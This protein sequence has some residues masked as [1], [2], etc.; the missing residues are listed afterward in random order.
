MASADNE[1]KYMFSATAVSA[2]ARLPP[3]VGGG[4]ALDTRAS[5]GEGS[6]NGDAQSN[7]KYV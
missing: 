7:D 6:S 4:G 1:Y 2:A 5:S 3:G